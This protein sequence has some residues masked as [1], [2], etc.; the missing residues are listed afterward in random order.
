MYTPFSSKVLVALVWSFAFTSSNCLISALKSAWSLTASARISFAPWIASAPSFTEVF[1]SPVSFTNF[2]ASVSKSSLL[3]SAFAKICASGSSP[4]AF[5]IVAFV[6]FFSLN[7]L[8]KSSTLAKV[9]AERIW[10]LSSSV[11]NPFSS[12]SLITS[13]FLAS[14]FLV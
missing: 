11:I 4:F 13:C 1:A 10:S 9:S 2:C 14:R 8:Y 5:A 12:I 7:G 6:F 3:S